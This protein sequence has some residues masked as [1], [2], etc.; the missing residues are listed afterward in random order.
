MSKK[1]YTHSICRV[2]DIQ[3]QQQMMVLSTDVPYDPDQNTEE[4]LSR[5]YDVTNYNVW[6]Q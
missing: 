6:E 1:E 3:P 2:I 4:A 5:E